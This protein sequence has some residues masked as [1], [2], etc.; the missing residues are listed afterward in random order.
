M[1]AQEREPT[2]SNWASLDQSL[3]W[4]ASGMSADVLVILPTEASELVSR[5]FRP[6]PTALSAC[7]I[8]HAKMHGFALAAVN[9]GSYRAVGVQPSTRN[10]PSLAISPASSR[11][12]MT[13][14]AS[15]EPRS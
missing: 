8:E 4:L 9:P 14:W 11:A 7:L 10:A 13:A 12:L 5:V 2:L 1:P 6:S 15:L 3:R